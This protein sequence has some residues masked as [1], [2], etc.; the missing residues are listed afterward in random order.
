MKIEI[1]GKGGSG[2]STLSV[3]MARSLAK[4]GYRV[5]LVD[6]DE[7][8]VG[9]ENLVGITPPVH[10]LEYLGGK[11]GFKDKLNQQMM[12]D[13][14]AGIFSGKQ[15]IRDLPRECMASSD[16]VDLVIIGKIHHFGEGCA[17]PIGI[18]SKKFLS[19]I[20][21]G[22]KEIIVMDT[23]AG[24]EHFG[25]GIV[26]ECDLV[27]GVIDPTAESFHLARKMEAMAVKANKELGFILNKVDPSIEPVMRR[28]LDE[29]KII[30]AIPKDDL[31][32]MESLEGRK[33]TKNLPEIDRICGRIMGGK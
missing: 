3:L 20:E 26:G 24:V 21:L 30:G 32:F 1:S 29:K 18:L 15:K 25:R 8:N 4:L 27:L 33:L 7:S 22:E 28:H 16:G 31:I 9:L 11:K 17:C 14:P 2:K 5:L 6:G 19:S 13:N 23:E 12:M 10:L